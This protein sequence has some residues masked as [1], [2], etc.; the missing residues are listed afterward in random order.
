MP[1][2]YLHVCDGSGFV[3]DSEGHQLADAESARK[4]ATDGLRDI[5]AGDLRNG[6]LNTAS[7]IDIEDEHHQLVA[8]V[9]F[10]EVVRITSKVPT[11]P[12]H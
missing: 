6:H 9:S 3:E 10:E 2:Y 1:T 11:R 7:F 8:T 5:L 4:L 12:T